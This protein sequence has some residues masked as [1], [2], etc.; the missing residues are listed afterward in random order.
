MI[1]A[2]TWYK[3]DGLKSTKVMQNLQD[4][5]VSKRSWYET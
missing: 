5:K 2:Y 3:L 4:T 1:D